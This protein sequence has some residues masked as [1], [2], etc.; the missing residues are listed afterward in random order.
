[1]RKL[2]KLIR[3]TT[4]RASA[5]TGKVAKGL[6]RAMAM[7]QAAG[8]SSPAAPSITLSEQ[9]EA[10][11]Y[12]FT[13]TVTPGDPTFLGNPQFGAV[14]AW[15]AYAIP[16]SFLNTALA[17]NP[18]APRIFGAAI[19]IRGP[20]GS[21]LDV[22][23]LYGRQMIRTLAVL[24]DPTVPDG[25]DARL[26]IDR[27]RDFVPDFNDG[28]GRIVITQGDA[29]TRV[30][31]TGGRI[32]ELTGTPSTS[33]PE[34]GAS[35]A[36]GDVGAPQMRRIER[37]TGWGERD[38]GG[39]PTFFAAVPAAVTNSAFVYA[40]EFD[41]YSEFEA[42]GFGFA[43]NATGNAIGLPGG[44]GS[45]II[46]SP[47][48]RDPRTTNLYYGQG[49]L[50]RPS[51][52]P[53]SPNNLNF[54]LQPPGPGVP[55]FNFSGT[56]IEDQFFVDAAFILANPGDAD[57]IGQGRG[58]LP[59]RPPADPFPPL[60][61]PPATDPV[62]PPPPA[63]G[64]VDVPS[65]LNR[66][67]ISTAPGVTAIGSVLIDGMLFGTST[68]AGSVGEF[69]VGYL[70]GSVRIDGDVGDFYVGGI[71][72]F[73]TRDDQIGT[74]TAADVPRGTGSQITVGGTARRI[75]IA[76]R[77]QANITVLGDSV[78]GQQRLAYGSYQERE[79]VR[80][81]NP[82]ATQLNEVYEW[83]RNASLFLRSP[84]NRFAPV[85]TAW[86]NQEF[87]NDDL[88]NAEFVSSVLRSVQVTGTI[89]RSDLIN[90]EDRRDYYAFAADAGQT[91]SLTA[92]WGP[93]GQ[94]PGQMYVRVLDGD[95]NVI[96][97]LGSRGTLRENGTPTNLGGRLSFTA[98]GTGVY[99]VE[100]ATE[101]DGTFSTALAY[102]MTITGMA[103]VTMGQLFTGGGAQGGS[104]RLANGSMGQVMRGAGIVRGDDQGGQSNIITAQ[105]DGIDPNGNNTGDYIES[106]AES[107]DI[108]GSLFDYT[109]RGNLVG[110]LLN[111]RGNVGDI[112]VGGSQFAE[113]TLM[114]TSF[115][116]G[117]T[118]GTL[119]VFAGQNFQTNAT[120]RR[121][122]TGNVG[123]PMALT[124]GASG[125]PGHIG[126]IAIGTVSVGGRFTLSTSAGSFVDSWTVGT[127]IADSEPIVNM[128]QGSDIRFASF[129]RSVLS[130]P[131]QPQVAQG[132]PLVYGQT[133]TFTDDSGVTFTVLISGGVL[134]PGLTNNA[135]NSTGVLRGIAVGQGI[136]VGR[137]DLDLQGGASVTIRTLSV[138]SLALGEIQFS[139]QA[140]GTTRSNFTFSGPGEIDVRLLRQVAVPL[141]GGGG[142][143]TN[144]PIGTI[145]NST[146]GGDFVAVDV[147]GLTSLTTLGNLGS[148]QTF[149]LRPERLAPRFTLITDENSG[150][151]V[152]NSPLEA[153]GFDPALIGGTSDEA[154]IPRD[155]NTAAADNLSLEDR[156]SIMDTILNGLV[157]RAGN[158]TLVSAGG[159]VGD[160][161]LQGGAGAVLASVI[162]NS[163]N[164]ATTGVF[165]GIVG[166]I[167]AGIITRV[168]LGDGLIGPG[169]GPFA[170]A[171]VFATQAIDTVTAGSRVRNARVEGIIAA[172][173]LINN[174]TITGGTVDRAF[175]L[176]GD[177][178]GWWNAPRF[179]DGSD[180]A[181]AAGLLNNVTLTGTN[182]SR[183]RLFAGNIGAIRVN[184][185]DIDATTIASRT[186]IG[187]ISARNIIDSTVPLDPVDGSGQPDGATTKPY[188]MEISAG[189]NIGSI[190]VRGA[191]GGDIKDLNLRAGGS[192]TG[193]ISAI[194]IVRSRLDFVSNI[195]TITLT[196]SMV[197]ADIT[198]ASLTRLSVTNSILASR[199][200]IAGPVASI[201]AGGQLTD[202]ILASTGPDGRIGII[203]AAGDITGSVTSSGAISSLIST[204]GSIN[205]DLTTTDTRAVIGTLQAARDISLR[206]SLAGAVTRII[207]G[208]NIGRRDVDGNTPDTLVLPGDVTLIQAG[209][210]IYTD[211]ETGGNLATI[212]SGRARGFL[213]GLQDFASDAVIRTGGRINAFN[214][215]GDFNGSLI[216]SSGGIGTVTITNGSF[217]AGTDSVNRIEARSG[218]ITAVNIVKGHLLGDVISTDGNIGRISVTGDTIFGDIGI[219]RALSADSTT[220]V[221]AAERRGQL[222][223][224]TAAATAGRDGPTI[225]AARDI[226]SITAAGGIFEAVIQAGGTV[227]VVTAGRGI[228]F[229]ARN[230]GAT[231]PSAGFGTAILGGDAVNTV[232]SA[233]RARGVFVGGGVTGLGDDGA[234]G[235]LAGNADVV[236]SG[237]V[238]TLTFR[239]GLESSTIIAGVNAGD[240]S[241]ASTGDNTAAAG[242]SRLTAV[243][244]TNPIGF[245]SSGNIVVADSATGT[246]TG[247]ANGA[248]GNTVAT[249]A[250]VVSSFSTIAAIPGGSTAITSAGVAI[251]VNGQAL[252]VSLTGPG[253]A[254][255]DAA[256]RRIVLNNT[257]SAS[258]LRILP[259]AGTPATTLLTVNGLSIVGNDDASLGTLEARVNIVNGAGGLPVVAIDGTVGAMNVRSISDTVVGAAVRVGQGVTTLTVGVAGARSTIEID[260]RSIVTLRAPGGLGT[261]DA[262]NQTLIGAIVQAGN[263]GSVTIT[264]ELRGLISSDRDIGAMII[265]QGVVNDSAIR[266][267]AFITS[268]RTGPIFASRISAGRDIGTVTISSFGSGVN[269]VRGSVISST[270]AVGVDLGRDGRFGGS[271][272]DADSFRAGKLGAVSI[273]GDLLR[274]DLAAGVYRAGDGLTGSP[275]DRTAAGTSSI[276]SVTV[277]GV[278]EGSLLL[279]ERYRITSAGAIGAV[280]AS[281]Q[282]FTGSTNLLVEG[283]NVNPGP[284]TVSALTVN[285]LAGVYT[286]RVTFSQAINAVADNQQRYSL[287]AGTLRLFSLVD[288]TFNFTINEGPGGYTLSYDPTTRTAVITLSTDITGRD[289]DVG[290]NVIDSGPGQF[291][292]ELDAGT[293]RGS[294]SSTLL[295]GDNNG[296]SGDAYVRT[297]YVGDVGDRLANG[298][299][300]IGD[301]LNPILQVNFYAPT[302]IPASALRPER[303]SFFAGLNNPRS[304]TYRAFLGDHP[305]ADLNDFASGSDIDLYTIEL[306]RGE[307][308]QLS[309]T[310]GTVTLLNFTGD[311]TAA[312]AGL[313]TSFGGSQFV[314]E[315]GTYI[316]MVTTGDPV[317]SGQLA[318]LTD[319]TVVLNL[320]PNPANTGAYDLTIRVW[321]DGD[322]GFDRE[323]VNTVDLVDGSIV[324]L[325]QGPGLANI[326]LPGEFAGADGILGNGDDLANIVRNGYTFTRGNGLNGTAN[327]NGTFAAPSDDIITGV[328]VA[329]ANGRPT[330]VRNAG[331]DGVFS[332]AALTSSGAANVNAASDDNVFVGANVNAPTPG[333]F[334]GPDRTL[335]TADD[336]VVIRRGQYDFVL[337]TGAN[338]RLDG[339][340]TI[341]TRSD[342]RVVGTNFLYGGFVTRTAGTDGIF[343]S[344]TAGTDRRF[345]TADDGPTDDAMLVSASI[346]VPGAI[347]ATP[348]FNGDADVFFL[349]AGETLTPGTRLRLTFSTGQTGGVAALDRAWSQVAIFEVPDGTSFLQGRF[350]A[351]IDPAALLNPR[352]N[353]VLAEDLNTRVSVNAQGD[354]VLEFTVPPSQEAAEAAGRFAVYI[355]GLSAT[356]YTVQTETL[357]IAPPVQQDTRQAF[358]IETNG[359]QV[360]WLDPINRITLAAF[361]GPTTANVANP[362][363]LTPREY[364]LEN[365]VDRINAY[366]VDAGIVDGLGNP[367]VTF[368]RFASEIAGLPSS[369]IFVT[370]TDEP[371]LQFRQG[372]F[373]QTQRLDAFN[374]NRRGEGVVYATPLNVQ[375][376]VTLD[377]AGLD[378]YTNSLAAAVAR[379]ALELMGLR[380]T[381]G[382]GGGNVPLTAINA[383][384]N[385]PAAPDVYVLDNTNRPLG[386][387]PNSS[388]FMGT[389]NESALL[390]RIFGLA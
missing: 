225:F 207:A 188:S 86:G 343:A 335:G 348:T 364:I 126:R 310:I 354:L 84:A 152:R 388:F 341:T 53:G 20:V 92:T 59:A 275:D 52:I 305:N 315:S 69:S 265:S 106:T 232:T 347:G 91:V 234:V 158:V 17:A 3:G 228:D 103:S 224:G 339:N 140:A 211:I 160:V 226:N 130:L 344:S 143:G 370:D 116:I 133:Q 37:I 273:S 266:A 368:T 148:A 26:L 2:E 329:P 93:Q 216:S 383:P 151:D 184:G 113:G 163:D 64:V 387:T 94:N 114:G 242:V 161:I 309:S 172:G 36:I 105:V 136:A 112:S 28:I 154:F 214:W 18:L 168:D 81:V 178:G 351:G 274:S 312:N 166:S 221:L 74:A 76:G 41:F 88:Y 283:R 249:T 10:R 146:V 328:P 240:A 353:T 389:Q 276:T 307:F 208:G 324:G 179:T 70:P 51:A 203:R 380:Q 205:L 238:G 236:R 204:R 256:T 162:A 61:V 218:D 183:S 220:G 117:G 198:G 196:G 342:D 119:E 144:S 21:S 239:G 267:G 14:T 8:S 170:R 32:V 89:G 173:I 252:L 190:T 340:G 336:L 159:S 337:D 222:P 319:P 296:I 331:I 233:Q 279:S 60:P 56:L 277:N 359:G 141:G 82:D 264:G 30:H 352:P 4:Q 358:L 77:S 48:T 302:S 304:F 269:L 230:I 167:F 200:S 254:G 365:L 177:L 245:V 115:L 110:G 121:Q 109:S 137:I 122:S 96:A 104:F 289:L 382:A 131:G 79:R 229:D 22:F 357:R 111:V 40:D 215:N 262:L 248:N 379:R 145:V 118:L 271:A 156:G 35:P 98:P 210:T 107:L 338:A 334:A 38:A 87:R 23:D 285:E 212:T 290:G 132:I 95:G 259:P 209:G 286:I 153:I 297:I 67:G 90:T 134:A 292:I 24:N 349:N 42:A 57:L 293:L 193:S 85:P 58:F 182:L 227:G 318:A 174:I 194:N 54:A 378:L 299:A 165:E 102:S 320:P 195:A 201:T 219:N 171:G 350:V 1:M 268:L 16:Q 202:T 284:L 366:F 258:T 72:G 303:S 47:F 129:P 100:L 311:D 325:F 169:D 257:T 33:T 384:A 355:Q 321:T 99:Y 142:G 306:Q 206:A 12:L 363:N 373:G 362:G 25:G 125:V 192:L 360:D 301:P 287:P 374:A 371:A 356:P 9:L 186:S 11:Q 235:G 251:T 124:T 123:Q 189:L 19:T 386:Q 282:A 120:L 97:A 237:N 147:L 213:A 108:S 372:R 127:E 199:V 288:G 294:S 149:S 295:D 175:F 44:P 314:L 46:G 39:Q 7:V 49:T 322:T 68:F 139:S 231:A 13:L 263:I 27:N 317:L 291:R 247:I 243:A 261:V 330:I 250:T 272:L 75:A 155:W 62:I 138:G 181:F 34:I 150:I 298:V 187:S 65:V 101:E 45:V 71:A 191:G 241:Y 385:P 135:A 83:N 260:T 316:V 326:P 278:I 346:G 361:V 15:F 369:T 280:R 223:A 66:M 377:Q 29:T 367:L 157:V 390:R 253:T 50:N 43:Q 164:R 128:G 63:V 185:G 217:R 327:G 281:G 244:I 308:F 80:S 300:I 381:G 255:Y 333:D 375:Q 270:I 78:S 197:R 31:I 73:W 376:G 313:V 176:V 246:V 6:S 180:G 323:A 345:G 332:N 55:Q 5:L